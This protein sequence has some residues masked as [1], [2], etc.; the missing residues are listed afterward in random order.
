MNLRSLVVIMAFGAAGCVTV[1]PVVAPVTFIP[2]QNPDV[3]WVTAHSGEVI[4]VARPRLDGE[5]VT[6]QW[7]GTS[8]RVTLPF[9]Q[10]R[11]V[12]AAQRDRGRTAA[13]VAAVGVLGGFIVWRAIQSGNG[14]G[15][16]IYVP[17]PGTSCN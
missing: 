17:G 16:C 7:L 10:I 2:Q 9:P 6:G 14:S 12:H 4:P 5:A 15:N 11:V 13:L 1:R 8:E 3:V